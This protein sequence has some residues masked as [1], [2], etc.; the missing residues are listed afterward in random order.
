[1]KND[2]KPRVSIEQMCGWE[3]AKKGMLKT[4][5]LR[6]KTPLPTREQKLMW[7][8][9]EHAPIKNVVWWVDID[10]LRQWVGVHLLRH[11]FILPQ[12]SSQRSDKARNREEEIESVL[13]FIKD[14]IVNDPDFNKEEWR[15]YR[16]QGST[17]DHSFV[18]NAQSFI[19]ISRK[20]LCS[21][22]SK[23]TREVWNMVRD[24]MKEI[25][26]EM[27]SVM[28]PNCVYRGWCTETPCCGY[29]L[30]DKFSKALEEYRSLIPPAKDRMNVNKR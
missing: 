11:P 24:C 1:M 14:D 30:G 4:V 19:N 8:I 3:W 27:A 23:E 2:K 7:L 25:D 28:V 22:A 16:L 20:R 10:N 21:K 29:V 12:I 5:G 18:I 6:P 26:P 13:K 15:D 9:S 17:N